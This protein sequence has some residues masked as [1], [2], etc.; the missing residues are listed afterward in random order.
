MLTL[1]GPG[2]WFIVMERIN[3][4]RNGAILGVVLLS[5]GDMGIYLRTVGSYVI[6][7]S[8]LMNLVSFCFG[9]SSQNLLV[10]HMYVLYSDKTKTPSYRV[11]L[12]FSV[13]FYC[14]VLFVCFLFVLLFPTA[15]LYFTQTPGTVGFE[16]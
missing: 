2:L 3:L 14:A 9:F 12:A 8:A 13:Y 4:H 1:C 5:G 7:P 15:L 6:N 16:G 10:F 11:F